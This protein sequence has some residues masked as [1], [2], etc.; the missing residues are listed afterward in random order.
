M[1]LFKTISLILFCVLNLSCKTIL[2][3]NYSQGK[4]KFNYKILPDILVY[5]EE[6]HV[7]DLSEM[8]SKVTMINFWGTWCPPCLIELPEINKL[9]TNL[10]D[11]PDID[12]INICVDCPI[13]E[14][15]QVILEKNLLGINLRADSNSSKSIITW[16]DNEGF[17]FNIV[18]N[19]DKETLAANILEVES[20][21][22]MTVYTLLKAKDGWTGSQS[23]KDFIHHSQK[24]TT[25]ANDQTR[26]SD[27][28]E[29]YAEK[30]IGN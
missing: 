11:E 7:Y 28:F 10:K 29:K 17:P 22:L 1:T 20:A 9:I 4:D 25:K 8:N 23:F 13:D 30:Y 18:L 26:F 24:K 2:L 15:Q 12:V 27:F 14:W 21:Q 3:N 5:D 19:R 16:S 6:S